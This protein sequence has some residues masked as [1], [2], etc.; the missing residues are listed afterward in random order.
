[1]LNQQQLDDQK[2]LRDHIT[3][4]SGGNNSI[5]NERNIMPDPLAVLINGSQ[6]GE[7]GVCVI[8]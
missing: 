1:M 3:L 4:F 8:E 2:R 6:L 7:A 5:P